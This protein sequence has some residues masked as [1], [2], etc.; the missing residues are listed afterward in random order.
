M[1]SPGERPRGS[2]GRPGIYEVLRSSS[3]ALNQVVTGSESST[4]APVRVDTK[5]SEKVRS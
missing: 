3:L 5:A 4:V 1:V 2:C